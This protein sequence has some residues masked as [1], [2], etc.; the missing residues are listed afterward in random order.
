MNMNMNT[1]LT[2]IRRNLSQLNILDKILLLF[3]LFICSRVI[4][5]IPSF[6]GAMN[7]LPAK[8]LVLFGKYYSFYFEQ[9][10]YQ[11]IQTRFTLQIPAALFMWLGGV[12][13]FTALLPSAIYSFSFILISWK[14]V[15]KL[16][17]TPNTKYENFFIIPLFLFIPDFFHVGLKGWGEVITYFFIVLALLQWIKITEQN[18]KSPKNTP[19]IWMG[20][21]IGLSILTKTVALITIPAFAGG[22]LY[23]MLKNK[24]IE[25]RFLYTFLGLLLPIV[26][27]ELWKLYL[28]GFDKYIKWWT[29]QS[30]A[31]SS[32]A[33]VSSK[34]TTTEQKLMVELGD[35]SSKFVNHLNI[36]SNYLFINTA[37]LLLYFI[38]PSFITV[39]LYIKGFFKKNSV[40]I[41]IFIFLLIWGYFLWWMAITPT[42]KVDDYGKFRRLLPAFI[43][44]TYLIAI[45]SQVVFKLTKAHLKSYIVLAVVAVISM[46]V[47][48]LI[49]VKNI[50]KT[51]KII[52]SSPTSSIDEEFYKTLNALPDDAKVFGNSYRQSPQIAL[53]YHGHF[54]DNI[55]Y[56]FD[57]FITGENHYIILD[58]YLLSRGYF[59]PILEIIDYEVIAESR[60]DLTNESQLI[61]IN[62]YKKVFSSVDT[63]KLISCIDKKSMNKYANKYGFY[64]KN[65]QNW[66]APKFEIALSEGIYNYLFLSIYIHPKIKYKRNSS[67]KN[68]MPTFD[69]KLNNNLLKS[70]QLSKGR[71]YFKIA[72]KDEWCNIDSPNQ[73]SGSM[74]TYTVK[75]A[76][77]YG[78]ICNDVCLKEIVPT[79]N[80]I[81]K[82]IRINSSKK[83]VLKLEN[84]STSIKIFIKDQESKV[85]KNPNDFACKIPGVASKPGNYKLEIFDFEENISKQFTVFLDK[86]E[87]IVRL[88]E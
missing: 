59:D 51:I 53:K 15:A 31:I 74:D 82:N 24:K 6:D 46:S 70:V 61:K 66:T 76:S 87:Q 48:C 36:T 40:P 72:L 47:T 32:Q 41:I 69:L 88:V 13:Y 28:M 17:P 3:Y 38:I 39:F 29:Y 43:M 20:V 80:I 27:Y 1:I 73:V 52:S 63:S 49:G 78:L 62:G 14:L 42:S 77:Y 75:S 2:N 23:Q 16:T 21:F 50:D 37:T 83:L 71:N 58:D 64:N 12:N 65:N 10:F 4:Y 44:N 9:Y 57:E 35:S 68:K 79:N 67:N 18:K 7:L 22:A 54:T 5:L 85:T 56:S 8:N 45:T 60:E 81:I 30:S 55:R 26:S 19:F 86:K 33:G 11:A 25:W 34:L 84:V